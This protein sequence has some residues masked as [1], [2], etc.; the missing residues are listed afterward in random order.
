MRARWTGANW[1]TDHWAGLVYPELPALEAK[2]RLAQDLLH[3][4]RLADEDGRGAGGW[5]EARARTRTPRRQADAARPRR[6]RA[7][8][9][10]DRRWTSA[11]PGTRW[12][13]GPEETPGGVKIAPNMPTEE[14][15]HEPHARATEGTFTCTFPLS[16]QGRLVEGCAESSAAAASSASTRSRKDRDFVAAYLDSDPS[17][18]GRR[19]GEV[20]LVDSTSR[21]GQSSRSILTAICVIVAGDAKMTREFPTTDGWC[22]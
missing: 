9:P 13:G 10:G 20:A 4:C 18:N 22:S 12:L 17:G 1:P 8:R 7:P 11:S 3:F 15:V 2:R 21:I 5:L 19:L 14:D 6:D 16:F